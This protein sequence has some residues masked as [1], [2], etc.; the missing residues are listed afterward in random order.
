MK[1]ALLSKFGALFCTV[2][3]ELPYSRTLFKLHGLKL[4]CELTISI[5]KIHINWDC[6]ILQTRCRRNQLYFSLQISS[7]L[8]CPP[9]LSYLINDKRLSFLQYLET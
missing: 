3:G 7:L 2:G 5:T 8:M 4:A 6:I 1:I 9:A